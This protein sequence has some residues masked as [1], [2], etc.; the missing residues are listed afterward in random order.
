MTARR[1]IGEHDWYREGADMLV[2]EQDQL[3]GYWKGDRARRG[4]PAD[5][6]QL[7]AVVSGQGTPAGAG[8]QAQARSGR[9]LEPPSQRPGQPDQLRRRSVG[10]RSDLAGDRSG[11]GSVDDLLQA[12]VLFFNGSAGAGIHARGKETLRDYVDR[13][14]FFFAEACCGGGEFDARAFAQLMSEVFPEQEY[15]LQLLPPEHPIWHAEEPVDP[16]YRAAAV[17]HRRRLP[18]QRGF[19]PEDLS[20]YW[21]LARP[22]R[23]ASRCRGRASRGGGGAP[24]RHQ[25]D[26]VR[27]ESRS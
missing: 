15:K 26:G 21:E 8:G 7:C 20:C 23:N 4:Q 25:R 27:H 3:S 1:F 14:G 17:G 13:G 19:C 10:S 9:R 24:H 6:H 22:R 11:G 12:P 16:Q 2:R 5:R 18:H